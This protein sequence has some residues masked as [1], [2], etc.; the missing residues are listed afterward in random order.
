[1]RLC[2]YIIR[3]NVAEILQSRIMQ[4]PTVVFQSWHDI[5]PV[6]PLSNLTVPE[7]HGDSA[8]GALSELQ[9]SLHAAGVLPYLHGGSVSGAGQHVQNLI[10][11]FQLCFCLQ[12]QVLQLQQHLQ[13][14]TVPYFFFCL[15]CK[16][17]KQQSPHREQLGNK[18]QDKISTKTET[19]Q[20]WASSVTWWKIWNICVVVYRQIRAVKNKH[21]SK[22][23]STHMEHMTI[24]QNV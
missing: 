21:T 15:F 20:K 16:R 8:P 10:L 5:D 6:R 4:V 24:I 14:W 17:I 11:P 18:I 9:Q 12:G 1:M 19:N 2:D 7:G 22:I 3:A 23:L 13:I